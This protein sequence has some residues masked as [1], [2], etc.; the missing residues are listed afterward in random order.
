MQPIPITRCLTLLGYV[1]ALRDI[2]AP[3][4]AGLRR[5]GLPTLFE[6]NLDSWLSVRKLRFFVADMAEHEGI[7]NLGHLTPS[8]DRQKTLVSGFRDP[9]FASPTLFHA[10]RILPSVTCR[11]TSHFRIWLEPV[12]DQIRCCFLMVPSVSDS[13]P[14]FAISEIRATELLKNVVSTFVG[15]AFE[16]TR[17]LLSSR[18]QDLHFDL[19]AAFGGVQVI[20]DQPYGAIDIPRALMGAERTSGDAERA[21]AV[22]S[23]PNGEVPLTFAQS[24][25]RCIYSYL[26]DGYPCIDL[27]AE[28]AGCKVRS[29]QRQLAKEHVT[30]TQ[31]VEKVRC[32]H[33][34]SLLRDAEM[35]IDEL[36]LALGYSERSAF[37]RAFRG[38]TGAS[39]AAYRL[40]FQR[41]R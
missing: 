18:A 34:L 35:S 31:I 4:D 21:H 27:A 7:V 24:L 10:L 37:A 25:E 13:D 12:G 22:G 1:Q 14:G 39:P 17:V 32:Q 40:Q 36:A 8:G 41:S 26:L 2:G 29:L 15:P 9:L 19:E 5:A 30:Y 11:Q 23:K 38:W 3:V 28:I 6:E 33:A 20:T 16:P